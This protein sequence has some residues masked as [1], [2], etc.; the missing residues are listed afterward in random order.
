MKL[1]SEFC[2]LCVLSLLAHA[3]VTHPSSPPCM[4]VT[5]VSAGSRQRLT[6]W[7]VYKCCLGAM[8]TPSYKQAHDLQLEGFT[9]FEDELPAEAIHIFNKVLS[10][11]PLLTADT[12]E[13]ADLIAYLMMTTR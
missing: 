5:Q 12:F 3:S 1:Q 2:V 4:P 13:E 11:I 9:R 6:K 10:L 8:Q 7:M